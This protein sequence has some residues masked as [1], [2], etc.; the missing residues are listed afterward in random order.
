MTARR[1]FA[2]VLAAAVVVG[3]ASTRRRPVPTTQPSAATKPVDKA[4]LAL[5][6]IAPAPVLSSAT[7]PATASTQATGEAPLDALE[8][9]AEARDALL[10][11]K[12]YN[13]IKLLEQAA[14]LDPKSYDIRFMLGQAYT[15]PGMSYDSAAAAYTA[16]AA[17]E[18]DHIAVH[19]ELG[20][21][22]IAK[23]DLPKAIEHFRRAMQTSEYREDDSQAALVDFFLA[24]A[25]QQ[26]GYDRAALDVYV[27][28][29]ER[30]ET[31][32]LQTRGVPE[33]A[34]LVNQ[35][36]TLFVQVGDLC[37][38]RGLTADALH[39][40]DLAAERKPDD[41]NFQAKLVR[42]L[43]AAGKDTEAQQH[44]TDVV[45]QFNASPA[46]LSLMKE[47]YRRFGGDEAVARELSKLH[48]DRPDDHTILY[49][50]VETLVDLHRSD[51]AQKQLAEAAQRMHYPSEMVR[52]L[53]KLY[54]NAGDTDASARLLIDTLTARP[55][56]TRELLPMWAEMLRSWRKNHLTMSRLQALHVAPESEASK[57][58]WIAQMA[59]IWGRDVLVR[60][61]LEQAAKQ[62][63]P[64]PPV[65]RALL[66]QYW[67]RDDWDQDQKR[68]AS[69]EL[70]DSVR[71]QGDEILALHL[72]GAL[73]L[74]MNE[75]AKAAK[76][77]AAAREAGD[78]SADL[79]L[80]YATA[81]NAAGETD[82]ARQVLWK[83]IGDR[84]T[85][86]EAYAQ[87]FSSYAST[88]EGEKV[89]EVVR[90]WLSNDPMSINAKIVWATILDQ[91]YNRPAD[92]QRLYDELFEREPDNAELLGNMRNFYGPAR[93]EQFLSKLEAK[94]A[95]Q[96]TN[97]VLLEALVQTYASQQHIAE[98]ARA[99]D[100]ARTAAGDDTDLLNLIGRL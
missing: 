77:F 75:P 40:Y 29:I 20:R 79:Q 25:L 8:L 9:F 27:V 85:L 1:C 38:K 64:F 15:G 11:R 54:D 92:A 53:F 56:A 2:I 39:L 4:D 97:R 90:T 100:A 61:S 70:I 32:G 95:E 45:Q 26:A 71:R 86:E 65:Y 78:N 94:R 49:A 37:N 59:R 35:P 46:A 98:A 96:P 48:R 81:L 50:L 18:P 28:L 67:A 22:S 51:E 5:D 52:R 19:F 63:P 58:F 73:M 66:G 74:A 41:F 55:D 12:P 60:T 72:S 16:A 69:Q 42:A 7:A 23:G 3:C 21:L 47:T 89:V 13:A 87:L 31:G 84:P 83:L 30:L 62:V 43:I 57:Q 99:L 17:L 88:R 33:L 68:K 76:E 80:S 44:A 82:R 6:E 10:Q 34:Y 24:R 14:A 91:M 93:I 36:E